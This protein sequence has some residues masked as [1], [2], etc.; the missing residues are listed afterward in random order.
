MSRGLEQ[1]IGQNRD[2]RVPMHGS[3]V[4]DSL[5]TGQYALRFDQKVFGGDFFSS[6]RFS[7]EKYRLSFDSLGACSA[8]NCGGVLGVASDFPS[9]DQWLAGT[10]K[11]FPEKLIDDGN[12]HH[13]DIDF[14]AKF[15]F[16]LAMEQWT[17][18]NGDGGD[19]FISS[20]KLSALDGAGG[21][22]AEGRTADYRRL[23][24]Q[25]KFLDKPMRVQFFVPINYEKSKKYPVLYWFSGLNNTEIDAL[26]K[27]GLE[28]LASNLI[29][30]EN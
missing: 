17:D 28:S 11:G 20:I 16:Y 2:D 15:D 25:S 22:T 26:Y 13:F 3:I 19:V 24:L 8:K 12:W 5:R 18:S 27:A 7:K 9:R 10:A 30:Q 4:D 23:T 6:A 1:W 29:N 21:I 14:D